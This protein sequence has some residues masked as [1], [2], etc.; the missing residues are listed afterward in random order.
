MNLL[1]E[2]D[3]KEIKRYLKKIESELTED[4][5]KNKSDKYLK[6]CCISDNLHEFEVYEKLLITFHNR[7][8]YY[9]FKNDGNDQD[10]IRNIKT[11]ITE[12]EEKIKNYIPINYLSKLE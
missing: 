5:L 8:N 10:N 12:L 6:C 7:L 1:N 11:K 4:D 3:M 9:L 2:M